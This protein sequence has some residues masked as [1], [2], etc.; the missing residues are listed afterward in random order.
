MPTMVGKK[1]NHRKDSSPKKRAASPC[2]RNK[3]KQSKVRR[4]SSPKQGITDITG[5][6]TKQQSRLYS[7][8]RRRYG[9]KRQEKDYSKTHPIRKTMTL[10]RR[11]KETSQTQTMKRPTKKQED[12]KFW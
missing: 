2:R 5:N 4:K 7:D 12:S 3:N 11:N 9:S 6:L 8:L 10:K 1:R